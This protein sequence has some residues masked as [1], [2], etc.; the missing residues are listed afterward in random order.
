VLVSARRARS[1]LDKA[2]ELQRAL[3]RAA[4]ASPARRF[5]TLF[6]KLYREDVL[7]KAWREVKTNAGSAGVD[8][9]TIE[10]IEQYGVE[11][12][13]A[14]LATEL[15]EGHYRPRAVRRAWIPKPDGSQ[16]GLGIPAVRDRVVQGA[17]KVVL[18]PI[19]EAQCAPR[20]AV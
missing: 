15:R 2:R 13:L 7:W 10:Q 14:D 6:D 12:F 4:K 20:G 19:F 1:T 17:A 3:Y 11:V 18:E 16:R 5:H 8:E 9:Q